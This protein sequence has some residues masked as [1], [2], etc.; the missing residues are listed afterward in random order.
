[1]KYETLEMQ[2][3]DPDFS[4]DTYDEIEY[5]SNL[6]SWGLYKRD[7]KSILENYILVANRRTFWGEIDSNAAIKFAYEELQRYS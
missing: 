7:K 4:Y 5:I 2:L 6:G 3:A 1:M